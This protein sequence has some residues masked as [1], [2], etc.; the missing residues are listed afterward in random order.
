MTNYGLGYILDDFLPTR[1]ATLLATETQSVGRANV[2]QH[3]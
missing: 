1:L 3:F 2:V